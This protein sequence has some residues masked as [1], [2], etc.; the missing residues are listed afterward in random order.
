MC[1]VLLPIFFLL[2]LRNISFLYKTCS[3]VFFVISQKKAFIMYRIYFVQ[4][5][6]LHPFEITP[7]FPVFDKCI[8]QSFYN[9]QAVLLDGQDG[10]NDKRGQ[11][12]HP[13]LAL[14]PGEE[15]DNKVPEACKPALG[16]VASFR[17]VV[18]CGG[19]PPPHLRQQGGEKAKPWLNGMLL[20]V[21][22]PRCSN[23]LLRLA[24]DGDE[25]ASVGGRGTSRLSWEGAWGSKIGTR[26]RCES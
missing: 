16:L 6:Q 15:G 19:Q 4:V 3:L 13:C 24:G 20:L 18:R 5:P 11:T 1:V 9:L 2:V 22:R 14:R 23:N 8:A 26:G 12:E 25:V 21:E 17:D 10:S 7:L